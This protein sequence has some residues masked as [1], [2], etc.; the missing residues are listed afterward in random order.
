MKKALILAIAIAAVLVLV[1]C[2][3]KAQPQTTVMPSQDFVGRWTEADDN[4]N[5]LDILE[6]NAEE[7]KIGFEWFM[8]RLMYSTGTA[9]LEDGKL[10]FVLHDYN[11]LSGTMEFNENGVSITPD[12]TVESY[13]AGLTFLYTDKTAVQ[14]AR[15]GATEADEE[16]MDWAA[17][18]AGQDA[19]EATQ[20]WWDDDPEI[21]EDG[22]QIWHLNGHYIDRKLTAT[23][24][25]GTLTISGSGA[26]ESS[27][28]DY[29]NYP[30]SEGKEKPLL[31]VFNV[32]INDG[33]TAIGDNAFYFKQLESVIIPDSVT[34]IG[35]SAFYNNNLT[36][37]IIPNSVTFIGV[38]AFFHNP[39]VSI[40][41]GANVELEND[42]TRS[43]P[44]VFPGNF[45]EVYN[46]GKQA[47]TYTLNN[48]KWTKH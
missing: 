34:M 14:T 13:Y 28:Y 33:I 1:G 44:Y 48:G 22:D 38:A 42:H 16:G 23:W 2:N 30:W 25:R 10:K 24:N 11:D 43:V 46:N 17:W 47:G 7:N 15:G 37:V 6:I 45:D 40:T 31:E 19:G 32:I 26:I 12:D 27:Y 4:D 20:F 29:G 3:K 9:W 39:L 41:I 35:D 21:T 5:Y 36:S 8:V 18:A